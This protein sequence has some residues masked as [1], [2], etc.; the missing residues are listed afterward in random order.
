MIFLVVFGSILISLL[1]LLYVE[2]SKQRTKH[3]MRFYEDTSELENI[4]FCLYLRAFE[5]DKYVRKPLP[6]NLIIPFK[7][8][9]ISIDVSIFNQIQGLYPIVKIT[10]TIDGN[11]PYGNS[12][13]TL[14]EDWKNHVLELMETCKFILIKPSIT[15]SLIWELDQIFEKKYVKKTIFI[16]SF[17]SSGVKSVERINR[18]RFFEMLKERYHVTDHGN[19]NLFV[20]DSLYFFT[21]KNSTTDY[22]KSYSLYEL[23][24][25]KNKLWKREISR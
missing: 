15:T 4:P 2:I 13:L 24:R 21:L 22:K 25:H 6:S 12:Q 9:Q 5:D 16:G 10:N 8:P 14:G 11:Q 20:E 18:R 3:K 19:P 1:Y 17:G 7:T 23:M